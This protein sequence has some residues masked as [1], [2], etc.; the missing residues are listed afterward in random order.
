MSDSGRLAIKNWS[1]YQQ[2][3]DRRP[4][5]IKLH[6]DLLDDFA[7][8]TL[9]VESRA[10][11]PM[12]WLLASEEDGTVTASPQDIAWRLRWPIE[13]VRLDELIDKGFLIPAEATPWKS[14]WPSRHVSAELR[15]RVLA[16][17]GGRCI[18]CSS[19]QLVEIDHIIPVS[20][21]GNSDESNL[22]PLCRKCN[23]K[24]RVQ[25][26]V[27]LRSNGYAVAQQC[28]VPRTTE[29]EADIEAEKE[30]QT[31]DSGERTPALVPFTS[32]A[33]LITTPHVNGSV[34]RAFD[35]WRRVMGHA[36]AKL[37]PKRKR[38]IEAR[39]KDSTIEEIEQAI[40]G[41]KGSAFH[42]GDN[43]QRTVYDDIA[44]ICRDRE[45][46]EKFMR[47]ATAPVQPRTGKLM[48][49]IQG[50]SKLFLEHMKATR[51][52]DG[53]EFFKTHGP[54]GHPLKGN[55]GK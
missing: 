44:L 23:R 40:E 36:A 47:I 46:V 15:A 12:L 33:A 34:L 27:A 8:S 14:P 9:S 43:D 30:L 5:W 37:T 10:I 29:T 24:K 32:T 53:A 26:R 6:R 21:G 31:T 55:G 49:A 19:A 54:D 11:L 39:L 7:F 1:S 28:V 51:P 3:K 35:S 52:Y 18:D 38:A 13:D 48:D 4:P 42:Q 50:S 45:H 2:Y 41:C 17:T 20:K 22:Q 25:I 16:K